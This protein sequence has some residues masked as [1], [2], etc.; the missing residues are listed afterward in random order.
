MNMNKLWRYATT[1]LAGTMLTSG[2]AMAQSTGSQK[3]EDIVVTGKRTRDIGGAI[4]AETVA[5]ARSTISQEYIER[6]AA[7][8]SALQ[9][10]NLLPAVNFTNNDPYGTSGGNLRIRG[11]DGNRI[12]LTVDGVP[13]NDTGNYA[14][15]SNQ[16]L[17]PEL[18]SKITVNLGSTDVDSPTAAAAGGTVNFSM[19]NAKTNPGLDTVTSFGTDEFFRIFTRGDTGEIGPL[20]TR[21]FGSA[22]YTNY[23]K[24]KGPGQLE[25][26]QYNAQFYQP[27][28]GSDFVSIAFHYNEN[29]NNFIRNLTLAQF[30]ATP[31]LD[32]D[33]NCIRPTPV[34]GTVQ[35][36]ST[37]TCTNY[38][39]LR[40]NPSNTG[41]IRVRSKFSLTDKLT[42]TID[43]S[44][45]YVLA[46][47]GGYTLVQETDAR[48]RGASTAA[49]V[50]LNGDG[51]T[52]DNVGLFSPN[53]TNTRRYGVIAGLIWEI[54]A[55]HRVR[56]TYTYDYGR[57]RQTGEFSFLDQYGNP[58]S[59]FGG[60]DGWGP[61]VRT[62]DGRF[63]R[64]RDRFSIAELNQFSVEYR[65]DY[66]NGD[67][68]A[69]VGARIPQFKRQL[70]Q[71]CFQIAGTATCTTGA[72]PTET[73]PGT[74]N[75]PNRVEVKYDKVLPNVGLLYRPFENAQI[76]ASYAQT[77]SAPRTDNLYNYPRAQVGKLK[78]ETGE[79]FDLGVRYQTDSL[80]SSVTVWKNNFQNRIQSSFDQ[81]L[82]I[83][84]DRQVGDVELKG[85]D[86]ELGYS[87]GNGFTA[88]ASASYND[89]S[90]KRNI[91]LSATTFAATAGKRLAETPE[92]TYGGRVEQKIGRFR[93][94]LD[95]KHVADRYLFDDNDPR[96]TVP[97][98]QVFNADANVDLSG[99]VPG[100]KKVELQV[101]VTNLFD[102]VYLGS[103]GSSTNFSATTTSAVGAPRT[104]MVTLKAGW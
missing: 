95:G 11:F 73:V 82:G 79:S 34:N 28:N 45:Q 56:A 33:N 60:K 54:N 23:N 8:Q 4:Q 38:Y 99:I 77:L 57:H 16:Q 22:S 9:Q 36:E 49:G 17:D 98:Y 32:N 26:K 103:L 72:P 80:I 76:F 29:R 92:W 71:F 90:Y 97:S 12:A 85:V 15:F 46:N 21:V 96:G 24:F 70:N 42:L 83:S 101:N 13:L 5:K 48:L 44:F 78:P 59:V 31:N 100:T 43:P 14:I 20:G 67:L 88:Y 41:N 3:F 53:N 10:I 75:S 65:G 102:K 35:N 86:A 63:L 84:V 87:P 37:T 69:T 25:K 50:D 94:G 19:I 7:G 51:D 58:A 104:V 91:P 89:S 1:A 93:L 81:D 18:L 40:I 61:K 64:G 27:L 39:N 62:A 30:L 6:Q 47:G 52:L 55:D 68:T 2:V 66:L 74:R